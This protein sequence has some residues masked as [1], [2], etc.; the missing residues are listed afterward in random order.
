MGSPDILG[1]GEDDGSTESDPG[2]E[3][4]LSFVRHS[5]NLDAALTEGRLS[6]TA[7]SDLLTLAEKIDRGEL[8]PYPFE[9]NFIARMNNVGELLRYSHVRHPSGDQA[10]VCTREDMEILGGIAFVSRAGKIMNIEP[11]SVAE[12]G[13]FVLYP[14]ELGDHEGVARMGVVG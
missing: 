1:G 11:E 9:L 8:S 4:L 5:E 14:G 3:T 2:M 6:Q 10:I 13:V 12:D 7:L